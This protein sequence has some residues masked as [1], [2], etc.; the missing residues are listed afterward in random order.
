MQ[1]RSILAVV[2][3]GGLGAAPSVVQAQGIGLTS[4]QPVSLPFQE[5]LIALNGA[6]VIRQ[7]DAS[8][9]V[10]D[11]P[12]D[13]DDDLD[14]F[15]DR[16]WNDFCT[17]HG[18]YLDPIQ[19]QRYCGGL[20]TVQL[21]N[22]LAL[23][24]VRIAVSPSFSLS[25]SF[26]RGFLETDLGG[27]VV[28]PAL[29]FDLAPS[30]FELGVRLD[31]TLHY[32]S[33]KPIGT[34]LDLQ[35]G[36]Q[37]GSASVSNQVFSGGLGVPNT[38]NGVQGAWDGGNVTLNT[39]NYDFNR[40]FASLDKGLDFPLASGQFD[41]G[42]AL[43]E[44][45]WSTRALGGIRLGYV[46]QQETLRATTSST[47]LS[48]V[49]YRTDIMG[50]FFGAYAGLALDK[51]MALANS[52]LVFFESLQFA[53][54]FANYA[55]HVND[56]LTVA[57]TPAANGSNS[58]SVNATIPTLK[59][60]IELGLKNDGFKA[61]L[62]GGVTSGYNPPIDVRRPVSNNLIATQIALLSTFNYYMAMSM[63]FSIDKDR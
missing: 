7:T 21:F 52:D 9:A 49:D 26:Q 46:G 32:S 33:F 6:C 36:Y 27:G 25:Q 22:D 44:I 57:G 1:F 35:F 43:P 31:S 38:G 16:R 51:E 11:V 45:D 37:K 34:H 14:E 4:R 48:A 5:R 12:C 59:A 53:A 24:D 3:A 18:P 23:S 55:L 15:S 60:G 2:F 54:G 19:Y 39:A 58:Y 50:G 41:L 42:G 47:A 61:S 63:F 10:R 17:T 29:K 8:G 62:S 40:T 13:D 30:A 56:T 28:T 20:L